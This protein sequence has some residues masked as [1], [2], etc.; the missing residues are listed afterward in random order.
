ME[1]ASNVVVDRENVI[2]SRR[3][4]DIFT[5]FGVTTTESAQLDS[6]QEHLIASCLR[7]SG[8]AILQYLDGSNVFQPYPG[9]YDPPSPDEAVSRVHFVQANKNEYFT[10]SNG[11][12]KLDSY[13]TA[14]RLAGAPRGLSA[15]AVT[16]GVTGF[17]PVL[18]TCAYRIVWGYKD[19]NNNL[20][21]G[22][23][24]QRIVAI[25]ASATDTA[26]IQLTIQIPAIV[27]TTYFYQIYRTGDFAGV[28]S[29]P[30]DEMQ[31]VYEANP[32]AG[33]VIAGEVVVIDLLPT[34][35]RQATLYTSPSQEGI[36]NANYE[37]PFANDVT[38]FRGNVIYA[39]TRL[40]QTLLFNLISVGSPGLQIGDTI[41]FTIVGGAAFTLTAAAS[42]NTAT[43]AFKLFT[44]GTPS[45]DIQETAIEMMRVLNVYASNTFLDGYYASNFDEIPGKMEITRTDLT[46]VAIALTSSRGSAFTPILPSSGS[47]TVTESESAPN[48][49]YVSKLQQPEAVPLYRFFDVGSAAYPIQRVL[50]L[51]DSVMILKEDGVFRLYGNSFDN[52]TV[53][54][55][56]N[57]TKILAPNSAVVLSNQVFFFSDVGVVA[58]SDSGV[59]I[60]SR[61]IENVLNEV[62]SSEFPY[63]QETTHATGY[64][65]D[66]KYIL[67]TVTT[68][69]QQKATRGFV[70]NL[71]TDSWSTWDRQPTVGYVNPVDNKLYLGLYNVE[72][73]ANLT[74]ERK[75][76]TRLDYADDSFTVSISSHTGVSITLVS[77]TGV[78]VGM[79]LKQAALESVI[80][81]VN[82][83]IITVAN[84]LAWIDLTTAD[85]FTP[86]LTVVKTIPLSGRAALQMKRFT[87]LNLLFSDSNFDEVDV[88]FN[89]DLY[90]TPLTVVL[91][92][93]STLGDAQ[94]LRTYI[95]RNYT[96]ANFIQLKISLNQA[97]TSFSLNG[98]GLDELPTSTRMK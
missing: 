92:T 4:F 98:Y 62:S 76:F 66:H 79:T 89:S 51:R 37:P 91:V 69:D 52:F 17:L 23:P 72:G 36:E 44:A 85:V 45:E 25:N 40:K 26:N 14:P 94:R 59:K 22:V 49:I 61:P 46:D 38:L 24:S 13:I 32:T 67:W 41:T 87:Q 73:A 8:S 53:S 96:R 21:L 83:N 16:N 78:V 97:F 27:D 7:T 42:S 63:F 55:L 58:A 81:T 93:N 82:G 1:E 33:Q 64:E 20:A 75:S 30:D 19:L 43:G 68:A 60:M 95:P 2:T 54:L 80:E 6:Y 15:T 47:T 5:S 86:I 35:L 28:A 50:A 11:I 77:T 3:G 71:L 70:Y 84:S 65:S 48:R 10:T 56:D 29:V 74:K 12:W 90:I 57:T 18:S 88:T 31:L 34:D 9:T 39:N